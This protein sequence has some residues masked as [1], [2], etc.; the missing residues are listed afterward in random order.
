VGVK[1]VGLEI[2]I[3]PSVTNGFAMQVPLELTSAV[4]HCIV[5]HNSSANRLPMMA[6]QLAERS[7]NEIP[8]LRI[9]RGKT[10]S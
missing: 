2:W 3:K 4:A 6:S 9:L 1:C 10:F 8:I 5:L 7:L